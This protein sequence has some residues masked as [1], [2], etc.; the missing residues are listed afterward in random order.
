MR[1]DETA[2]PDIVIVGA[3]AAGLVAAATAVGTGASVTLLERGLELGGTAAYSVGEI[4][5]PNNRHLRE[6]RIAD[7][8][9]DCL[10]F[11]AQLSY[12]D[13]Y[14]AES[15]YLGLTPHQFDL[16]ATYYDR[17]SEAVEHL[18]GLGAL[19]TKISPAA[20]GDPLGHP[21]YHSQHA[22]N[23]VP[24][25]RHLI[26]DDGDSTFGPRGQAYV[27]QLVAY[28]RA[29]GVQI[30]TGQRVVD[31]FSGPDGGVKGVV[32]EGVDGVSSLLAHRAVVFATGGF[33]HNAEARAAHLRGPVDAVAAVCTNT[34]DFLRIGMSIG[35]A[36]ANM[37]HAFLGNTA[38]EL[39]LREP[40][41]RQLTHF[42]FGDSMIWVDHTGRRVVNEKGV[43]TERARAHF[44][45]DTDRCRHSRR[46]LV[47][48]FDSA[49]RDHPLGQRYPMP[50]DDGRHLLTGGTWDELSAAIDARLAELAPHTGGIRLTE[51]FATNLAD[52]LSRF[53]TYARS[54]I[55][56][57]FGRGS[58]PIQTCYEP[59][60]HEGY[61]NPTMAPFTPDGPYYA[62]LIGAAMFDTVGGPVIDSSARVLDTLGEP[63][64]GLFGAGCCV[65]SPGGQAYWSGGAPIGLALTYGYIAGLNAAEPPY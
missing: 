5:V 61:P 40:R 35:A 26:V 21:E 27:D 33:G 8:R 37:T 2:S 41:I 47:Q 50:G 64:P 22:D 15:P 20:Y 17:A 63:F 45:W 43:F 25:G 23:R 1:A 38:F 14:A 19:R 53:D 59:R 51:D 56:R 48:V 46:V 39:G 16:L 4:W 9:P 30:R 34:G 58:T 10:R 49:V 24:Q 55:D 42:P 44:S 62:M 65:A 11:M 29:N 18:E 52:S 12:P 31:V 32:V 3:G 60:L 54:G 13:S 6:R 57:D 36:L 7:P 28:L